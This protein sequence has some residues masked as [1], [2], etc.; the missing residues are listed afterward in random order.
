M[1]WS[2][3]LVSVRCE[4]LMGLFGGFRRGDGCALFVQGDFVRREFCLRKCVNG[5]VG[6]VLQFLVGA[7]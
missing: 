5:P 2:G 7:A 3:R 4:E 1:V 6:C